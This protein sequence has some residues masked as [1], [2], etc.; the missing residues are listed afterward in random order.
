[1]MVPWLRLHLPNAGGPGLFPGQGTRS[2]MLQL[3][4]CMLQLSYD[5]AQSNN[6]LKNAIQFIFANASKLI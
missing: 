2:H 5:L 4:V 3:R 6:K 1:M